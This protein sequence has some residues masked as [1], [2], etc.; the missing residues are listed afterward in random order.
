MKYRYYIIPQARE[1][2]MLARQWYRQL[3][4]NGLS[5][6]FAQSVKETIF[7]IQSNPHAFATRYKDVRVAHSD[8]FPYA[9]HFYIDGDVI[10]ITAIIFQ[11]R[12]PIIAKNRV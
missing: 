4:V 6:R 8:R 1:E 9:L 7:R 12:D 10:I 11:G 3:G 2:F 5:N